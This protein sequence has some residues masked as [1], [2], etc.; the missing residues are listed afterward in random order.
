MI[1]SKKYIFIDSNI[2]R[3]IFSQSEE[4]SDD[5]LLFLKKLVEVGGSVLLLP[6]QVR[7]EVERNCINEWFLEYENSL[8][9]KE[10]KLNEKI[11]K[12]DLDYKNYSKTALDKIKKDIQKEKKEIISKIEASRKQFLSPKSGSRVKLNNLFSIATYIQ[13]D[14]SIRREAFFRKEK[15]NPPKDK[16]S[17]I[18]DKLIWETLLSYFSDK[19]KERITLIFVARD[20]DAWKSVG[21][22]SLQFN[23]WLQ[24]E[25]KQLCNGK[26]ILV[27]NLSQIPGLTPDEQKKIR[28]KEEEEERRNIIYK[29]KVDIPSRLK[30]ANTFSDAEKIMHSLEPGLNLVDR[31]FIEQIL[32]ASI[33]NNQYS[34][35]PFNQVLDSAYAL[36][37]FTKLF[38][39]S[40]ESNLG[41]VVWRD[42]Y[43]L[44]D[45]DQQRKFYS[46][47]KKLEELGFEFDLLELKYIDIDDIPF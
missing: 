35:G 18:G 13:E 33:E 9:S 31:D 44:L 15:G 19:K 40:V 16:E 25:F 11:T 30:L 38:N 26:V 43:L 27:E 14:D 20:R 23:S 47:R 36:K 39:K 17:K 22:E 6:Q 12:L 45:E 34:A 46:I 24:K 2:Y 41:L 10:N 7:D 28:E 8:K 4:F 3:G 5:F 1:Q 21:V 32:K 42:F 37:F 29:L